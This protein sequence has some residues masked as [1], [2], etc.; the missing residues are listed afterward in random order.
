M[1]VLS[2]CSFPVLRSKQNSL[3]ASFDN[4]R[5]SNPDLPSA[6]T[7]ETT[8]TWFPHTTGDP[9]PRP[10]TAVFHFTFL[11]ALQFNG[12]RAS[13]EEPLPVGPRQWAQLPAQRLPCCRRTARTR[14]GRRRD[15]IRCGCLPIVL[16]FPLSATSNGPEPF[17]GDRWNTTPATAK[18]DGS[19]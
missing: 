17:P 1:A 3:K 15:M 2:H 10:G 5:P 7:A 14:K 19:H 6:E 12:G 18:S 4:L 13:G 11:V 9:D 16:A 8:K